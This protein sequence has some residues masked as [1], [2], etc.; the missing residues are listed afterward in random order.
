LLSL[1]S[2]I[3]Y[4]QLSITG[5]VLDAKTREPLINASVFCENTTAGTITD[6]MGRF[7]LLLNPGGYNLIISY[8]GYKPQKLQVTESAEKLEI[9]LK[10]ENIRLGEVVVSAKSNFVENG[11]SNYGV[12]FINNFIG[13][14]PNAANC[15]LLN[16][17]VL[18]FYY[19]GS[20]N[21]IKVFA[22]APLKVRNQALGYM[23]SYQL[24]SFVYHF[25]DAIF[26]Y[27]GTCQYTEM[28]GTD[29]EKRT[30]MRNRKSAYEGSV[31]YFMRSYYNGTLRNDGWEIGLQQDDDASTFDRV[32]NPFDTIYY[33]WISDKK[34]I[35][36]Y[37]TRRIKI[38]Y[39]KKSPEPEYLEKYG[40]ARNITR[41]SS[42]VDMKSKIII[43]E[44][45]Y[46]YDPMS[47]ISY[48]YWSWKNLAD[49][50]PFDYYP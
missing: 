26:S 44:N 21:K 25:D 19:Y 9:L 16:P 15:S 39:S 29:K 22:T 48:N 5:K 47:W 42:A 37:Y 8:T 41:Q 32:A 24:D 20:D 38:I 10:R 43:K 46:Y 11:W 14:T 13:A 28:Q 30:W 12:F 36:I 50:L 6:E 23:L 27:Q 2:I 35:E 49:Q 4:A 45:G 17:E 1:L 40:L 3:T 33:K 34:Q 7:S 31:L 18:K